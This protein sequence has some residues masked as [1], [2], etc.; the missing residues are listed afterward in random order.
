MARPRKH[1]DASIESG[2]SSETLQH[3]TTT[4]TKYNVAVGLNQTGTKQDPLVGENYLD[5]DSLILAWK[6]L[7]WTPRGAHPFEPGGEV[8]RAPETGHKAPDRETFYQSF[9]FLW[10]F[11]LRLQ[12]ML[13]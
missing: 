12:M 4:L 10:T 2:G 3:T 7:L 1:Q 5:S 9:A 8:F 11:V 6:S 13:V